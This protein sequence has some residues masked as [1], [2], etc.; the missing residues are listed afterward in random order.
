PSGSLDYQLTLLQDGGLVRNFL[1]RLDGSN[2]Y[3]RY[4][5]TPLGRIVLDEFEVFSDA[6][7]RQVSMSSEVPE[8]RVSL[9][10]D[11]LARLNLS[12]LSQVGVSSLLWTT[13]LG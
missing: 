1:Q 8:V 11:Q 10:Y 6:V 3:S 5:L 2:E 12:T 13:V 9:V 7:E 4:A